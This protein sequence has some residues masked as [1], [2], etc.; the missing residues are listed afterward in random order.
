LTVRVEHGDCRQVL[1]QFKAE[2]LLVDS[3]VTDTPYGLASIV[4]RFGGPNAAEA[5]DRDGAFA[6]QS[7]GFMGQKWDDDVAFHADMWRAV[8]DVLKPGGWLLAFSGTRTYHRMTG[9]IE[10]AGFEVRDAIRFDHD[11]EAEARALFSS[12]NAEQAAQLCKILER[13]PGLM[14]WTYGT[15]FPKSHDTERAIARQQCQEAGRHYERDLPPLDRRRDDDHVCAPTADSL[16]WDGWGTALKPAFEP[17]AVARK[18][19]AGNVAENV[20]AHGTGALNVQG[21][22]IPAEKSV[23]WGGGAGG[24]NT[25]N[26]ENCGLTKSGAAWPTDARFPAN[27]VHDASVEVIAAYP[28]AAGQRGA[29]TGAEPSRPAKNVYNSTFGRS[30]ARPPRGD[31]GSAARFF[32]SAKADAFDR[33]GTKHPTVKPIDLMQWLC[34]LVTRPGGTVLDPFAGSGTTGAACIREGFDAVLIE[35]EA[36][37]V[38]DIRA[39]LEAVSEGGRHSLAIK[40]RHVSEETRSGADLPLFGTAGGGAE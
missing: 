40:H 33:F 2:G 26:A 17:I 19:L 31:A 21:C 25:W 35:R 18:P 38:A 23:G 7:R 9:A 14:A 39:R 16:A 36:E 30:S 4:A 10:T 13:N 5:K 12:L 27:V 8:Y 28:N 6:R 34:R 11:S 1:R 32:Y 24:G 15:G 3:V 20:L 22:G 29:V 37:Y